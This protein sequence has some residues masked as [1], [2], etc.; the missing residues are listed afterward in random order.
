M[1]FE[2]FIYSYRCLYNHKLHYLVWRDKASNSLL[3]GEYDIIRVNLM[4]E[5]SVIPLYNIYYGRST[6]E[7]LICVHFVSIVGSK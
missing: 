7:Y 5:H 2:P 3:S 6:C 1:L 4:Y